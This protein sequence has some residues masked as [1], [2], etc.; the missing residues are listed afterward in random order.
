[1]LM[2]LFR[3]LRTMVLM[4]LVVA[5]LVTTGF[6]H[7]APMA[8]DAAIEG[9]LLSGFT[10]A[11]LCGAAGSGGK[12]ASSSCLAC[13]AGAAALIPECRAIARDADLR[14]VAIVKAPRERRS[15]P[16]VLDLA[17]ATR[18]PPLA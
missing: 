18:G 17:R 12:E 14:L 1:M 13:T 6:A 15:V 10:I 11:D 4:A 3:R 16:A 5:A 9:F 2:L 8:K 7:R